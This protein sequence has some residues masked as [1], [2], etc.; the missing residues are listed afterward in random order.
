MLANRDL[1]KYK[2]LLKKHNL[3]VKF[4]LFDK[5]FLIDYNRWDDIIRNPTTSKE[6]QQFE[7]F[8]D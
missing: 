2:T 7:L 4:C 1:L 8:D 3:F 6:N 5:W